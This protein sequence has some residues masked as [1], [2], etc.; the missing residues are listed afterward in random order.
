MASVSHRHCLPL[1]GIC[2]SSDRHCLV[3]AFVPG[4]SLDR[5][6]RANEGQLS[7]LTML[8]WAEQ[9]ADGMA[10][11]EYRGIIHRYVTTVLLTA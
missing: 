11:L 5:Y 3:S 8:S 4:G 2:L 9:I 10:Y 6:L 1:I 7:S